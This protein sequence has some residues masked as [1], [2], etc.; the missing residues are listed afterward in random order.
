MFTGND[1]QMTPAKIAFLEDDAYFAERICRELRALEYEVTHFNTGQACL[2]HL[3]LHKH[4]VCLFD[5]SLPDLTGPE[6]M[7]RLHKIGRMPPVIFMTGKDAEQDVTQV[8]MA[9]ADDYIIK[10]PVIG[11]LHARIQALLRRI[12]PRTQAVHKEMLGQLVID[13]RNQVI[14]RNGQPVSLTGSETILA[15]DL[16]MHRGQIITRQHLYKLLGIDE[17]AID[18]RRLDVHI[19]HLRSKLA[20]NA[21][22]GW[23]LTSV[24]QRGYRLEYLHEGTTETS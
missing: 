11:V 21:M 19:S 3:V 16:F 4:D 18:T 14:L 10:P 22:H 23:K 6:V 9:G 2:S 15:F 7:A 13:Y 24:Y 5:W 1:M 17:V 8:L 12:T 20:L